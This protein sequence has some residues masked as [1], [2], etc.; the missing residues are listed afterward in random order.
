LGGVPI[1]TRGIHCGTL[2]MYVLCDCTRTCQYVPHIYC[3]LIYISEFPHIVLSTNYDVTFTIALKAMSIEMDMSENKEVSLA[4]GR[5][6]QNLRTSSCNEILSNYTTFS[7]NCLDGQYLSKY[8]NLED[9]VITVQ[10][11]K[12]N[13]KNCRQRR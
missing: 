10:Y 9:T 2:Y 1:P 4:R 7:W 3:H 11:I 8:F 5:P 12:K 13:S 6:E